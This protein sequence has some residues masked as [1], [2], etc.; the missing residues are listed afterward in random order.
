M[1]VAGV[2]KTLPSLNV[3]LFAGATCEQVRWRYNPFAQTN[4]ALREPLTSIPAVRRIGKAV[5]SK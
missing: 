1:G 4:E 3:C 2:W 5:D